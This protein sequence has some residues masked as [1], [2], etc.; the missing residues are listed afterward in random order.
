MTIELTHTATPA[1]RT[2]AAPRSSRTTLAGRVALA[3]TGVAGAGIAVAH[4]TRPELDPSWTPISDY[5]LGAAGVPMTIAFLAWAGASVAATIAYARSARGRLR[6]IAVV[7]LALASC[8]PL[9][10]G[11]FP[12]DPVTAPTSAATATGALHGVG[13]V[14][15]DA[16]L[17]ASLLIAL[18]RRGRRLLTA[19]GRLL[20]AATLALWAAAIVLTVL[21]GVYLS[22]T[23]GV[24]GPDT[25]LGWANRAHVVSCLAFIA[26]LAWSSRTRRA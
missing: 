14:L 15:P 22:A 9:L 1:D 3:L 25:P 18:R 8:G 12:A 6:W 11:I 4:L 10:A 19:R 20:V 5:A 26:A 24:L 23:G 2:D 7:L 21:S 17:V 16:L 13:A